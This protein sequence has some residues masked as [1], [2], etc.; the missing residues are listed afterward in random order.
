MQYYLL[1]KQ[2]KELNRLT[3][4]EYF[5]HAASGTDGILII[6][7]PTEGTVSS[8]SDISKYWFHILDGKLDTVVHTSEAEADEFVDT[9]TDFGQDK[10]ALYHY[11][12]AIHN[13]L[14]YYP[15]EQHENDNYSNRSY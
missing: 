12:C 8:M 7:S 14:K 2:D 1:N 5:G 6:Y 15:R 13:N 4:G 9:F 10:M 11:K 3:I